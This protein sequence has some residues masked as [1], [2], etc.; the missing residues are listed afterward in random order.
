MININKIDNNYLLIHP[1]NPYV[2]KHSN[3]GVVKHV[4]LLISSS[5]S[6][7]YLYLMFK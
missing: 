3:V 1:S 7:S 5:N 6:N 4:G 2:V